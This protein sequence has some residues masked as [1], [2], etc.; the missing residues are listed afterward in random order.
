MS[1]PSSSGAD[2]PE[3][4]ANRG[5]GDYEVQSG[6]CL[7]S[8]AFEHGFFWKTLWELGENADLKQARKNPDILLPGD[9]VTVPPIRIKKVTGATNQR[10]RLQ[11]KGVPAKLRLRFLES[12]EPLAGEPYVIRID[13][14]E[15]SGDLDDDGR[16]TES[17]R[18]NARVA[19][20]RVGPSNEWI[21]IPLGT[22][23]PVGTIFG[24][25]GR[26]R[27]LG[28]PCGPIDGI[29]GPKTS[30]ALRRFQKAYD[31]DVTGKPDSDTRDKLTEI[32]GC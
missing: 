19:E 31:L 23:D 24:V 2:S 9:L 26:L 25:Q 14:D 1:S 29:F 32:Y 5:S 3:N 7:S 20:I 21:R 6:D 28:F 30:S 16:L 11:L 12:G 22:V 13:G 15:C 4:F 8:I 27:N 10:H 17:I 18:P